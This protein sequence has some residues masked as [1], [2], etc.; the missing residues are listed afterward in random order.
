MQI[1]RCTERCRAAL[2]AARASAAR[3]RHRQVDIE[4]LLGALLDQADGITAPL[5]ET[6]G[7]T[8]EIVRAR[9]AQD[10]ERLAIGEPVDDPERLGTSDRLNRLLRKAENEAAA[11]GD[12]Y[13][14]LEHL[15]VALVGDRVGGRLFREQSVTAAR[16]SAALQHIRRP[17]RSA[18][19]QADSV[20]GALAR[21]GRDLTAL[22]AQDRLDPVIGR[23]EEMRRIVQVLSRRTKNNPVLIG[24]RGVGKT[25]VVEGLAQRIVR[26]DVVDALR[27]RRLIAVDLGAIVAGAKYRGEF[28]DRLQAVLRAAYGAAG[29]VILFI[30]E[31]HTILDAGSALGAMHAADLL[32]P[33]LARGLRCIGATTRDAYS[34]SIERDPGLARRFQPVWLDEPTIQSTVSILRGLRERYQIHHGAQ[35]RDGALVAAAALS[36]RYVADRCLPDKAIDLVDEAAATTQDVAAEDI[37]VIVERWTGIPVQRL[38]ER[39]AEK[40]LRLETHLGSRV[41]G[42]EAAVN[43]VAN[44]VIRA[45]AGLQDPRRP[46]GSF[47]FLGPTGVGKTEL[48]RALAELLFGN[49]VALAAF[50]MSEY[51]ERSAVARLIGAPPGYAGHAAGGLLTELVRRRPSAVVLFEDIDKA[52]DDVLNLFLHILDEGRLSDGRGR[53]VTFR[54]T[55]LIMTSSIGGDAAAGCLPAATAGRY[56]EIPSA[57]RDRFRPEFLNRIDDIVAFRPLGP[58]DAERI[59]DAH[60]DQLRQRL[61]AHRIALELS[62]AAREHLARAGFDPDFGARPL[63][64]LL[65]RGVN[66]ALA[67]DVL[68]GPLAGGGRVF[69]DVEHGELRVRVEPSTDSSGPSTRPETHP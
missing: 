16:V 31:L 18:V 35:I 21:Y 30:D 32:K 25:A 17:P 13:V 8:I 68:A 5:L 34:R 14:N 56:D 23:D 20:Q 28:E 44:A 37:A 57:L 11:L 52:H 54:H 66:A 9:L 46:L 24:D 41:V 2:Q 45:R 39:E 69:V 47:L 38:M 36:H 51:S 26:Q 33:L 3:R 15:V 67:R 6:A 64:R 59:V 61:A 29:A 12:A 50:D 19:P 58:D 63:K 40:L 53:L 49:E 7:A 42:Q 43:A 22:A 1:E 60:I 48:A 27:G 62:A 10:M 55:L 4:H 65:E